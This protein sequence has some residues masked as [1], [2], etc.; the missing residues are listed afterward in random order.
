M[1]SNEQ[2]GE[3]ELREL[4]HDDRDE[5]S[6]IELGRRLQA[7]E[8]CRHL[9]EAD[10]RKLIHGDCDDAR[11]IELGRQLHECNR[12]RSALETLSANYDFWRRA[13]ELLRDAEAS[14]D[15]VASA[16]LT[17]ILRS[18]AT[19]VR[20]AESET[21]DQ[22][23][24]EFQEAEAT[25]TLAYPIETL[26]DPPTHPEMLG[27]IGKYDI[28]KVVGSGGMGIVLKAHDF[29]LNRPLAIKILAPHL[30][31]NGIA[32]RRF[33]QEARAAAGVLHPNV[34]AVHG[35]NNEGKTPYIVM[36]YVAGPSLQ[37][38]VEESGPLPEIEIVRISLQIAA[39]LSAAHSQGLVHRD[40]KPA[41][42]LVEPEVNRVLITDFG[43]ARCEDDASLTRTG[44]LTGT[45]NYMSPEQ[46]RGERPD[47]RSDLFSF[48]SLIYFL[49]TGRLP[50][51]ADSPLS[52]LTRIQNEEPKPV[53]TAG[54][55]VSK[56]LEDIITLMLRKSPEDRFQTA[57]E[58][59][60]VLERQL[61]HLHQPHLTKSPVVIPEQSRFL[62]RK[63]LGY[64]ALI[65][66]ALMLGAFNW[67]QRP[68]APQALVPPPI[69]AVEDMQYVSEQ[70]AEVEARITQEQYDGLN[71]IT[72]KLY[73][74]HPNDE[75]AKFYRAFA[76][77]TSGRHH[78]AYQ[79]FREVEDSEK[80]ATLAKYNI[81]CI[82]AIDDN[83]EPAFRN[84]EAS[85]EAGLC[86]HIT[87]MKFVKDEDL[88][89]LHDDPRFTMMKEKF[90]AKEDQTAAQECEYDEQDACVTEEDCHDSFESTDRGERISMLS[91][92][93]IID[94]AKAFAGTLTIKVGALT[95]MV[96]FSPRLRISGTWS[97]HQQDHADKYVLIHKLRG[98]KT[99]V[100]QS[101]VEKKDGVNFT[102]AALTTKRLATIERGPGRLS[103]SVE[104]LSHAPSGRFRFSG[105]V[106]FGSRL[107]DAGVRFVDDAVLFYCFCHS[108]RGF[109]SSVEYLKS[110]QSMGLSNSAM[111]SL[112]S[113]GVSAGTIDQYRKSGLKIEQYLP[114]LV[115]RVPAKLVEQYRS[116]G[117]DPTKHEE[118]LIARVPAKIAKK[119]I[120]KAKEAVLQPASQIPTR[121][122]MPRQVRPDSARNLNLE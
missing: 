62:T 3:A 85:I 34:I 84:L 65:L 1:L 63:S 105:N 29:D 66:V 96:D 60:V 20:H 27:S 54:A 49:S 22:P 39:G 71:R 91:F 110:L 114:M 94:G 43:L 120:A 89:N 77:L 68:N 13:P 118:L 121:R 56:T 104:G 18:E 25:S 69:E 109:D 95:S 107:R 111:S 35:V 76:L 102:R 100:S 45:P 53:R 72:E 41:N 51:R 75:G 73:R 31:S 36:P 122:F 10:I 87:F 83:K 17:S 37:A 4:I 79:L 19:A 58:L 11:V 24:V 26:L 2:L 52:V 86:D 57:T 32:R 115:A 48:G 23:Q 108:E 50:F 14:G 78:R 103:L 42:I 61:A 6:V 82:Y 98:A 12:C 101:L 28:E 15:F 80:Y 99:P 106:E 9:D 33:A 30:A 81:A 90:K 46:A 47:Q 64:G 40:I 21:A 92:E 7:C 112:V 5:A 119:R 16:N 38:L 55:Q 74:N 88:R 97:V 113:A 8:Q 67:S 70:V 117:V 93:A 116:V 59:H 44:W